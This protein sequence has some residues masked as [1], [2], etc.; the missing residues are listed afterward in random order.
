MARTVYFRLYPALLKRAVPKDSPF[1]SGR[2]DL[3]L[4][5]LD[6]QNP[7]DHRRALLKPPIRVFSS[8]NAVCQGHPRTTRY[9]V[10]AVLGANWSQ[11]LE[12][13]FRRRIDDFELL[14]RARQLLA[15]VCNLLIINQMLRVL[16][17][18]DATNLRP[19]YAVV[20]WSS[21]RPTMTHTSPGRQ[22]CLSDNAITPDRIT[23][24]LIRGACRENQ[25]RRPVP[26]SQLSPA[27]TS[28]PIPMSVR[29]RPKL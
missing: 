10:A 16:W 11:R 28:S 2:Q 6:P 23:T 12:A 27:T 18:P 19:R 14:C 29:A 1:Q 22:V 9:G 7:K 13:V 24:A 17:A 3:N 26:V 15:V 5:P 20:A 21:S 25:R 4:R 8:D